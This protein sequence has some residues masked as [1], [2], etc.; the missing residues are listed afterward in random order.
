MND[1]IKDESNFAAVIIS[2]MY[3]DYLKSFED[4]HTRQMFQE[5]PMQSAGTILSG[6]MGMVLTHIID[7]CNIPD[8]ERDDI[9]KLMSESIA[10]IAVEAYTKFNE[11]I[12]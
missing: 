12:H 6:I 3:K 5:E 9:F 4:F 7:C 11:S 10:K 2:N 1:T 8:Q